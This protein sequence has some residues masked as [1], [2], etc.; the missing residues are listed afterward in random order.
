LVGDAGADKQRADVAVL[1]PA[2]GLGVRLGAG[3]PKALRSL[4]GEPLLLHALR[5]LAATPCVAVVIVAAPA[6]HVEDMRSL[7]AAFDGVQ[8]VAGGATRQQSV[9]R[10]LAAVPAE[11]E[12]I[13]VHDA[14]RALAPPHLIESVA[15][16][17]RDGHEA[18]IPVVPLADTIKAVLDGTVASTVDRDGL[19]TVQTP[20][21]FRRAVLLAAHRSAED[22]HT[23][24]AGLVERMGRPVHTV[25]GD[26]LALKITRPIDLL[27]AEAM[28]HATQ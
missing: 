6:D 28:L 21:G 24:D 19:R 14:A 1:V 23:D 5:R 26:D 2:A 20:Q 4:A 7:L 25:P 11:F 3:R 18:V 16:A 12:I 17:V 22:Q 9:A 15:A 27:I 13:L 8:V 10:A